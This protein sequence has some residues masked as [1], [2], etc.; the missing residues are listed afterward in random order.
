MKFK[1]NLIPLTLI[2]MMI[3][4]AFTGCSG[5]ITSESLAKDYEK[6]LNDME[7]VT[8]DTDMDIEMSVGEGGTSIS[9]GIDGTMKT[10]LIIQDEENYKSK[11]KLDASVSLFGITQAI[12]MMMYDVC[13]NGYISTYTNDLDDDT[14]SQDFSELEGHPSELDAIADYIESFKLEKK[15]TEI[16]GTECY[17]MHGTLAGNESLGE[18]FKELNLELDASYLKM[19]AVLY[20]DRKTHEPVRIEFVLNGG[21]LGEKIEVD[22]YS[23]AI[24]KFVYNVDISKV[25]KTSDFTIP[26]E[27]YIE[28]ANIDED[29]YDN[30]DM[31]SFTPELQDNPL[32][33]EEENEDVWTEEYE[34]FDT[35]EATPVSGEGLNALEYDNL[36]FRAYEIPMSYGGTKFYLL[37]INQ[38]SSDRYV[39]VEME[40]YKNGKQV[41]SAERYFALEEGCYDVVGTYV[42]EEYDEVKFKLTNRE[43]YMNYIGSEI[44]VDYA[45]TEDDITGTVTNNTQQTVSF[46]V[47]HFVVWGNNNSV[48]FHDYMYVDDNSL[49]P[50]ETSNF[51]LYMGEDYRFSNYSVYVTG[52]EE[53][54]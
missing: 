21:F 49:A 41:D 17:V 10:A 9:V 45:L 19:D 7:S 2:F 52:E 30:D 47:V 46:P 54:E 40:F 12:N 26:E 36:S 31:F 13:E 6:T 16:N 28:S 35:S 25:N 34:S 24:D 53:I 14:W 4:G 48:L 29:A 33:S 22:D 18:M 11:I 43:V 8:L 3:M 5:R 27:A 44:D 23:I 39:Y 32:F 20:M 1:K 50:G 15:T 38:N 42:E 37:G 51:V